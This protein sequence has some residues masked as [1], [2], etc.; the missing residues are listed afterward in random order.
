MRLALITVVLTILGTAA[1][2]WCAAQ[3]PSP[4]TPGLVDS[5]VAASKLLT[6][7]V[8]VRI[9]A[10]ETNGRAQDAGAV[11]V[12]SGASLGG[13]WIATYVRLPESPR[14][15]VTIPRDGSSLEAQ[16][17][18]IDE[19]SGLTLLKIDRDKLPPLELAKEVPP[20]GTPLFTAAGSGIQDPL[21]SFGILSGANRAVGTIFPPL[22]QCDLRAA[23]NASGAAVVDARGRLVGVVVST[24]APHQRTG[25]TYAVPAKYAQRLLD[26][27]PKET[28]DRV[29]V[30]H[31]RGAVLGMTLF[32]VGEGNAAAVRVMRVLANGPAE[33]AGVQV[34]D[35]V[36]EAED[37]K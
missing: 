26:R 6:S 35:L 24:D 22:M 29:V 36:I 25:W 18:V 23:G 27:R 3:Q 9:T 10:A 20:V 5:R 11:T 28:E 8:T 19:Y 7:T 33:K 2:P 37:V 21:V 14:I 17:K 16:V 13:G 1:V 15:R 12:A 30:L 31:R 4:T 32:T 34:G